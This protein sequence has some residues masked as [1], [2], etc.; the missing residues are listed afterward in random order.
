MSILTVVGMVFVAFLGTVFLRYC[1]SPFA[2][3]LPVVAAIVVLGMILPRIKEILE[4]VSTLSQGVGVDASV[5]SPVLRGIGILLITRFASGVCS[6]N[7]QKALGETVEYCG[8]IF[9][10]SLALPMILD[11]VQKIM[12]SDI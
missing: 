4:G 7:G 12:E 6:D 2:T 11:L 9:V 3:L 10:V 5:L 1:S 8:Q